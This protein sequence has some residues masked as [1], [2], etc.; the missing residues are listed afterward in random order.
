MADS[1]RKN[2]QSNPR[3]SHVAIRV[4]VALV[5]FLITALIMVEWLTNEL[6]YKKQKPQLLWF[7]VVVLLGGIGLA[8]LIDTLVTRPVFSLLGQVRD[9]PQ[10]GWTTPI[11]VPQG[12]GEITELGQALEDLRIAVNERNDALS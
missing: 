11:Q 7:S 12:R 2:S 8:A 9:A 1:T 4:S 10:Q 5:L 3:H 6:P